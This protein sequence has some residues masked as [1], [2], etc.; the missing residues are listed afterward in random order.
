MRQQRSCLPTLLL[1]VLILVILYV[2]LSLGGVS[3][4]KIS[5]GHLFPPS[6]PTIIP[7]E[8]IRV[9]IQEL[10]RLETVEYT[11]EAIIKAESCPKIIGISTCSVCGDKLLLV[12]SG[13]V[14]GGIDL[15]QLEADDIWRTGDVLYIKLP[16]AEVFGNPIL[17]TQKTEVY[18]RST[19]IFAIDDTL[20]TEARK[21][22]EEAIKQAALDGDILKVA[23][24][25]AEKQI[26]NLMADLGFTK[27]QFVYPTPTP[28]P[29]P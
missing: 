27:V 10:G 16:E 9:R 1:L 26:S 3:F 13:K 14:I 20:E 23:R 22:A 17:D 25:N 24:E 5:F 4:P 18:D 6:T 29:T 15:T 21:A 12:A 2:V 7:M 11:Q 28:T 19:C 8:V